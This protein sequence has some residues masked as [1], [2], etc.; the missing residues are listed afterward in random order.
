ML[1]GGILDN[2]VNAEGDVV[3]MRDKLECMGDAIMGWYNGYG[4]GEKLYRV[5][6]QLGMGNS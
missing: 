5:Y 6:L 4:C 2:G 3:G 1:I